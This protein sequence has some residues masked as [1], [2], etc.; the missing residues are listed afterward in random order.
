MQKVLVLSD[1]HKQNQTIIEIIKNENPDCLIFCGDLVKDVEQ[2]KLTI[3]QYV[4]KGNWDFK[5]NKQIKLNVKIE[6]VNI[7]IT[8]GHKFKVKQNFLKLIENALPTNPNIIC[9]GHTH[10]QIVLNQKNITLINPGKTFDGEYAI[11]KIDKSDFSVELKKL[12]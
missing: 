2:L 11:I 1:S 9:F 12:C 4:V 3:P 10:I 8:H 7:F 6:N 5:N